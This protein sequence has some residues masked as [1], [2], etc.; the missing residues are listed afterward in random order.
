MRRVHVAAVLTTSLALLAGSSG[1]ATALAASPR[2]TTAVT[3]APVQSVTTTGLPTALPLA[4]RAA[5]Q[6]PGSRGKAPDRYTPP[7]GVRYNNPLGSAA[8]KRKLLGHLI[9]TINSVPRGE[10]IRIASWNIRSTDIAAALI[11]AHNRGVSV[12]AV[13]DRLNANPSN[14]NTGINRM[15]GAFAFNKAK[16]PKSRRSSV[17]KCLSSCRSTSGIAHTKFFLFSKAAK[18]TDVVMYGSANATDLAA[19]GQWND[20][21]TVREDPAVYAEF[22][23]VFD[24]MRKDRPR[25]QPYV[26]YDHGDLTTYFY[27]YRG[28]ATET[29]PVLDDLAKVQCAGATGETGTDGRTKIRIAQTAMLGDRGLRIAT[30]LRT[31]YEQGCDIRMVYAVFGNKVLQV[32]RNTSRG[33]VPLRQI[34]QDFNLDGV[35]DRYLH[36]KTM[37]ISGV[38]DGNTEEQV[39]FNGSSNWT[40]VALASDE[41]LGKI[42]GG[43]VARKYSKWF[44]TLYRN[45]PRF[46]GRMATLATVARMS[47]LSRGVSPESGIEQN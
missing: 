31:L 27:P 4:P 41:I 10:Q 36:M 18:T 42:Y 35:Y 9:R 29:D 32:L 8:N 17:V 26:T 15:V 19:Y 23:A 7:V 44:D 46:R 24:E 11:A 28:A 43:N 40:P 13:M 33:A 20:L 6:K 38:Y 30:R 34:A 16:R 39:T 2:A 14:P 37:A 1:S 21:Y 3:Q 5:R 25:T 47:A 45:P 12:Q 22:N